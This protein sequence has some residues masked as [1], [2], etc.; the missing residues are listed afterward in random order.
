[1]YLAA[2][3]KCIKGEH[4]F[5]AMR[6]RQQQVLALAQQIWA[7]AGPS[8]DGFSN[9]GLNAALRVCAASGDA[10]GLRWAKALWSI[11]APKHKDSIS[12]GSFALV[13]Q[14]CSRPVEVDELLTNSSR[15]GLWQPDNVDLGAL[16]NAAGEQRDWRR[17]EVLWERLVRE[18][19]VR[20]NLIAYVAR[21]KVHL[22]C[23]RVV[24][25]ARIIDDM[26]GEGFDL[27]PHAAQAHIQA[28]L[29]VCH[30]SLAA[31]DLQRLRQ[32]LR[33]GESAIR[34]EGSLHQKK[35]LT[36]A[37][38]LAT[39]LATQPEAVTLPD[40]LLEWKARECSEMASWERCLA[41]SLYAT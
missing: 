31:T 4:G 19:N 9:A 15:A 40:V 23:G 8:D 24:V 22:L 11:F 2:L 7:E 25:A 20:P 17:A 26:I 27:N 16:V 28:L 10:H 14:T 12:Y 13:L 3:F 6:H 5:G 37:K 30:S 38:R 34:L 33:N 35:F 1:M 36:Q 41:G 21:S 32:A 18:H 39:L 29:V